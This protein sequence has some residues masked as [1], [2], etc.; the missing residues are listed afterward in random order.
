MGPQTLRSFMIALSATA[1][2]AAQGHAQ[3]APPPKVSVAAAYTDE[4]TS[5]VIFIGKGEAIDKVDLMARVSGFVEEVLVKDGDAVNTGDPLFRIEADTYEATL[6]AREADLAQ[7]EANLHLTEVELER[8][9]ELY[10]REVGTEADRDVAYANNQ[11]AIAQVAIAEAAIQLAKLDVTYTE[12]VA[13]FEGRVGRS[14]VSVG[15]LVGPSTAPL[16]TL[17]RTAPIFVE[18]SLTEKQLISVIQAY[19][20]SVGGLANNEQTPNVFVIL[21]NGEELDESG[22]VVFADNRVDPTTGT[23]P[24]RAEFENAKGLIVDGSF[25]KVRIEATEPTKVL[26]IPQAAV[27][28]DQRGDFVL[29]VGQQQTVEQR[30]VTLG[31]QVETAVVVEDG[32]R[33]GEAVIVEGL[34]RVRPG[35]AVDSVLA[36]TPTEE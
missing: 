6:S 20:T 31:R 4:L 29:V 35:V 13:P 9:T 25:L 3:D 8:K 17:V 24:V 22:R 16:I 1:L 32:M 14:A 12:V 10:E 5:Q 36:G 2:L 19:E 30:Y 33:E 15:E 7:A 26:M 11:V 18:F 34:Q 23:I 21:P 28:R 27:Q